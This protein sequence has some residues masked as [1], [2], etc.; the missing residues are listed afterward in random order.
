MKAVVPTLHLVMRC[1]SP[2]RTYIMDIRGDQRKAKQCYAPAIKSK[3]KA[4]E[5]KNIS[6]Q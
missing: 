2:D 3:E 5:K 6:A 1:Q 4:K